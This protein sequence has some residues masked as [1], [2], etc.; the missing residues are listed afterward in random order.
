MKEN[1]KL[2]IHEFTQKMNIEI[3][4]AQANTGKLLAAQSVDLVLD[5]GANV[6]QFA[7]RIRR[8]GYSNQIISFEP[9]TEAHQVLED[10]S[11]KDENWQ[12]FRR[13]AIGEYDGQT[14]INVAKNSYSSSLKTIAP[15]HLE[16]AP[17]SKTTHTENV[18]IA[19]IDSLF[20]EISGSRKRIF[21]KID[22]QG[23]EMEVLAGASKSLSKIHGLQI[24]LSLMT[25]YKDQSLYLK[26][27]EFLNEA[28]FDVWGIQPGFKDNKTGRLL[29]FD[30][31]LFRQEKM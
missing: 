26:I 21:L 16:F 20:N 18:S 10:S 17:D 23:Y 7:R 6:G 2:A 5:V 4:R 9:L 12:T 31:I 22:T 25:L 13:T 3:H 14:T 8:E 15:S 28:G 24:E 19:T 27:L 29:Q 1:L 11:K 30:A